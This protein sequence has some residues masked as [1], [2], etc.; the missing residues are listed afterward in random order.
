MKFVLPI[1]ILF[2]LIILI[3]IASA[4]VVEIK[5]I[6]VLRG[7]ISSVLYDSTVDTVLKVTTEFYNIGSAGYRT[8][9]RMDIFDKSLNKTDLESDLESSLESDLLYRGWS[10]EL[11]MVPGLHENFHIYWYPFN[12]SGNFTAK[13]RAYYGD[14]I[15]ESDEIQFE[16]KNI[17]IPEAAFEIKRFRTYDNYIK[18]DLKST[19]SVTDVIIIPSD[20]PMGWIVEQT[21]IE[22]IDKNYVKRVVIPYEPSLWESTEITINI[23]TEDGKYFTSKSFALE[24]ETGILEYIHYIT[25]GIMNFLK[26]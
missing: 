13:I 17:P 9:I 20:Y 5:V 11:P 19:E 7:R 24:R 21:K 15:L 8:R 14:E 10:K 1:I 26:I 6:E 4:Q 2:L 25:D 18:F 23:A 22:S 16:V 3:T 12:V